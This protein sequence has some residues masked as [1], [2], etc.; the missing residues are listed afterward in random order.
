MLQKF[1]YKACV[2]AINSKGEK[3]L[4]DLKKPAPGPVEDH[5][6]DEGLFFGEKFRGRVR[7]GEPADFV[8]VKVITLECVPAPFFISVRYGGLGRVK[9]F[10]Q[11]GNYD[12]PTSPDPHYQ[13]SPLTGLEVTFEMEPDEGLAFNQVT[14]NSDYQV[15]W[16]KSSYVVTGGG[17]VWTF[18][19]SDWELHMAEKAK[20]YYWHA[21]D[22]LHSLPELTS[23][24]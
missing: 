20:I 13:K 14:L 3:G 7:N 17:E 24:W 5:K 12:I 15:R 4:F 21:S 22:L 9:G 8:V 6:I 23:L 11:L 19:K 16:N 18:P 2:K 10:I 1:L